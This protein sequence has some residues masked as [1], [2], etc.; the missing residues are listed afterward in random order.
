MFARKQTIGK[1][2]VSGPATDQKLLLRVV[3][4]TTILSGTADG[5]IRLIT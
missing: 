1:H 3:G 5:G 2:L 4:M